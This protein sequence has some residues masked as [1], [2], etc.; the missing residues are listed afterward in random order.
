M[1]PGTLG[2]GIFYTDFCCFPSVRRNFITE[3][4][5]RSLSLEQGP[6]SPSLPQTCF[7]F[8]AKAVLPPAFLLSPFLFHSM[9]AASG[10]PLLFSHRLSRGRCGLSPRGGSHHAH[11]CD[12]AAL[13]H[14]QQ[15]T[16]VP[17]PGCR[18]YLGAIVPRPPTACRPLRR[19]P[20]PKTCQIDRALRALH[21]DLQN[22]RNPAPTFL[23]QGG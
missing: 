6:M 2:H 3:S 8:P 21:L 23:S 20:L 9:F 15:A 1:N 14:V 19:Q 10:L 22:N 16:P 4:R 17:F 13:R 5:Q 18:R 7:Y 11:R 12:F